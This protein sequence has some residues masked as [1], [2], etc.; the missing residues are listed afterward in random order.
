MK[1][2]Q[3]DLA[4]EIA[5]VEGGRKNLTIAQI[6]EVQ[7]ILLRLLGGMAEKDVLALVRRYQTNPL[8]WGG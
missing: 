6:K 8:R 2:N 3:N 7:K 4:V 5:R 1:I